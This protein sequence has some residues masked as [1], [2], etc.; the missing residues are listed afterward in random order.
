M[1]AY[2]YNRSTTGNNFRQASILVVEDNQDHWIL[3][4]AALQQALPEVKIIWA[5][6]AAQALTCLNDRQAAG[7]SLPKLVLLDLYL[8]ESEQA[9]QLLR[10]IKEPGSAFIRM[11]VVVFSYSSDRKDISELY[12]FGGTSFITKPTDYTQWLLYFQTMRNYWWETVT[13]PSERY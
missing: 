10:I 5:S 8:P 7:Q 6:N 4:E 3:I 13:L 11:P 1:A 2:S 12:S 9:W